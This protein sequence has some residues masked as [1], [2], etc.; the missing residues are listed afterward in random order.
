LGGFGVIRLRRFIFIKR[1]SLVIFFLLALVSRLVTCRQSDIKKLIA[2]RR[3]THITF[4][5]LAL[6]RGL[7]KGIIRVIVL[8]LAHG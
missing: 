5:I 3:V 1:L 6:L 2:Y 8:S 7:V 4:M